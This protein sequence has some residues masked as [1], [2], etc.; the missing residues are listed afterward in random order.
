MIRP[1]SKPPPS[2]L[3]TVRCQ[4]SPRALKH[5]AAAR[6]SSAVC[7]CFGLDT[8]WYGKQTRTMSIRGGGRGIERECNGIK[9]SYKRTGSLRWN[10]GCQSLIAVGGWFTVQEL[11][12]MDVFR[13]AS[14]L[15]WSMEVI[16]WVLLETRLVFTLIKLV[17]EN[18]GPWL[19]YTLVC[20]ALC[21]IFAFVVET[22][23]N[24][25]FEFPLLRFIYY[26]TNQKQSRY[27]ILLMKKLLCL[28]FIYS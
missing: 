21:C 10:K 26:K 24:Y 16:K 27:F 4:D 15:M 6:R 5:Q 8:V 11:H 9:T 17:S 2:P 23:I 18:N 20:V 1:S 14:V 25:H 13:S 12:S 7:N 22:L 28:Q 19:V 3:L